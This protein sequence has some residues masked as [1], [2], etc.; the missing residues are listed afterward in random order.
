MI[1]EEF[2]NKMKENE[3]N[4]DF[5]FSVEQLEQFSSI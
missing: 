2:F 4:Y 3:K 1:K 5:H